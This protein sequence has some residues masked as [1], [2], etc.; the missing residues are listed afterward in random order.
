MAPASRVLLDLRREGLHQ[1]AQR[2]ALITRLDLL[3]EVTAQHRPGQVIVEL[4]VHRFVTHT[5]SLSRPA[6]LVRLPSDPPG[7]QAP[8]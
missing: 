3:C 5:G 1:L 7:S 8:S 2:G 4:D 6:L